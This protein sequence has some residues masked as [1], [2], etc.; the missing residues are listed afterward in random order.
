MKGRI[1][2]GETAHEYVIG[3]VFIN[4]EAIHKIYEKTEEAI[5]ENLPLPEMTFDAIDFVFE[6]MHLRIKKS[7]MQ[8]IFAGDKR[9]SGEEK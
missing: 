8:M 7:I 6:E 2:T 1:Y 5:F 9:I 4:K 3:D